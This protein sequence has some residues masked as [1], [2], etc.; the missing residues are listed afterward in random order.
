M[1]NVH[2]THDLQTALLRHLFPAVT[3]WNRLEGRTRTDKFDRA[4]KAE[5]RDALWMIGRQWQMG[6]FRGADA[7]SPVLAKVRAQTTVLQKFQADAHPPEPFDESMPLEARVEALSVVPEAGGVDLSLDLRLLAGRQWL[8]MM[9][10]LGDFRSDFLREYA[11][12]DP[13]P[14]TPEDAA[15]TAHPEVWASFA[16]AAGRQVDGLALYLH[17]TG[18]PPGHAWDGITALDA[19]HTEVDAVAT[20]FVAWFER[21]VYQPPTEDAWL[22][23][24]LEYQFS[25]SA[26]EGDAEKVLVGEQYHHRHLDWYSVDVDPERSALDATPNPEA[27]ARHV[28]TLLPVPVTFNGMPNTRWWTFEDGKTSFG[29]VKPDTTDLAKL[30]LMEF[31]LVYANDW[32]LIPYDVPAGAIVKVEGM[33]VTNVF[34]ERTWVEPAGAGADDDWQRWAMFVPSTAGDAATPADTSLVLL[35]AAAATLEGPVL[36]EAMLIRDEMANMV[37]GVERVVPLA[38]GEGKGG[39]QAARE[40]RRFFERRVTPPAAPAAPAADAKIRYELMTSVPEN[41]IPFLPVHVPDDIREI[42]LQ[43]GRMLRIVEGDTDPPAKVEPRTT[44]LRAGLDPPPG[45]GYFLHEE[46]VPRAGVRV[47]QRYQRTRWRDG[48]PWL[49][50]GVSKQTGRGEGSSRLA[51]DRIVDVPDEGA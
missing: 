39:A 3:L 51:F 37:W 50:L 47:S 49:W 25:C 35:P 8:K 4:L 21:L 30:L 45:V 14:A 48:R 40:T 15:Y 42:Q 19:L 32:F 29:D 26:P 46:E 38:T 1:T 24:R 36:E 10:P 2:V 6:E 33:S 5:I 7:G 28:Y 31:G 20:R 12:H 11:I 41:W 44:L 9:Q 13:D 17:L 27:P 34:G 43:R 18:D 22:P 23:D 16:A